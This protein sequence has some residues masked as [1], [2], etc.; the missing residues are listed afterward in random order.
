M[1]GTEPSSRVLRLQFSRRRLQSYTGECRPFH[2][3]RLHLFKR[4][5]MANMLF[6]TELY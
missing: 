3:T 5:N 1:A 6:S 2:T 4:V